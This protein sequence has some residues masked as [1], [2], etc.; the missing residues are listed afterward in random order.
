MGS[1]Y[2]VQLILIQKLLY[3]TC[4]IVPPAPPLRIS[5]P[6]TRRIRV[7][8]RKI[9]Y[10]LLLLALREVVKAPTVQRE[11]LNLSKLLGDSPV[12]AEDSPNFGWPLRHQGNRYNRLVHYY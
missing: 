8:P 10:H 9:A 4:T 2:N 1:D 7:G 11:V 6:L 3:R 5:E 12:T